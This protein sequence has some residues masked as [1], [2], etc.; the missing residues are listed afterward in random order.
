LSVKYPVQGS[1]S[2]SRNVGDV[3]GVNIPNDLLT[4]VQ[5]DF[6]IL[7][8][9]HYEDTNVV[10]SSRYCYLSSRTNRPLVGMTDFNRNQIQSANGDVL[11]HE[12]NMYLV[13][14][15][16]MHTLGFSTNTYKYFIDNNGKTLTNHIKTIT[17]DGKKTT[18]LDLPPLTKRL[19]NHFGCS[20]LPGA[21]MENDGGSGN[22][23]SHFERKMFFY[24]TMTSG[25]ILSRR[26]SQ[27]SLA[28]LE[29][30]GWYVP[31]YS[32][33]EPYFY[34][35]G[36]GCGF[37][38]DQCSSRSTGFPLDRCADNNRGCAPQGRAGGYCQ[39]ESN[40]DGCQFYVPDI[41]YDCENADA[42]DNARL[43]NLQAFGRGAGSKCFTGTLNTRKSNGG[44][45]SFCFKFSCVT[46]GASTKLNVQVGAETY[47]CQE[48]G[49]MMIDG[50]YGHIDCPDPATFCKTVGVT[51]CPRN[52]MGRGTCVNGKCQCYKNNYGVDCGL[53]GNWYN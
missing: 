7:Y 45:T 1:L 36:E 24:E 11:I 51:Y 20:S 34:G 40:A 37:I 28:L 30:S 13:M 46:Q 29:G 47:T 15:E 5:A 27:F 48:Q 8:T 33:A 21:I 35:E 38:Y 9:S 53:N 4:G 41:D 10:A 25:N 23:A 32:Y 49:D 18:V 39:G 17:Y 43:P 50:Y 2:L 3:C 14:H 42:A 26:I 52:C 44:S 6:Y 16:F 19:R 12:Q 31:D 22:S